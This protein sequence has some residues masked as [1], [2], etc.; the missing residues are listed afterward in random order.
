[1]GQL[2]EAKAKI[3]QGA[4]EEEQAKV[5]L[6]MQ[7]K[8]LAAL[9]ARLKVHAKEAGDNAKKVENSMKGLKDLEKKVEACG[10]STEREK[11]LESAIRE[12]KEEIKALTEVLYCLMIFPCSHSCSHRNGRGSR[13]VS[14]GS[15][16]TTTIQ[17]QTL[18]EGK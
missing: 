15:T 14:V 7:Q 10:W 11:E 17:P 9:E 1:M 5:K 18:I 4:A 8:E 13:P 12:G 6:T 3:A 16:S 2:A